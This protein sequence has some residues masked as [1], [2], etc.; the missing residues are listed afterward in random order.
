MCQ[1]TGE[2]AVGNYFDEQKS[3]R[4]DVLISIYF[5]GVFLRFSSFSRNFMPLEIL[6]QQN[7]KVFYA[8]S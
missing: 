3:Q 4:A 5:K 7:A 6:N 8:K 1:K 2:L